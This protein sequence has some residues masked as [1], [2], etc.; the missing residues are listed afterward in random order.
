M[1]FLWPG[2]F[3]ACF[4]AGVACLLACLPGWLGGFLACLLACL[5]AGLAGLLACRAGWLAEEKCLFS[6]GKIKNVLCFFDCGTFLVL[7]AVLLLFDCGTFV[8]DCHAL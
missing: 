8:L 3:L 4:L 7:I 5:L 6:Y 2:G 1:V